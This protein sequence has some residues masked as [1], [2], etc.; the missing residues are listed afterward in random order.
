M[1]FSD[2]TN[3]NLQVIDFQHEK[4]ITHH[5]HDDVCRRWYLADVGGRRACWLCSVLPWHSQSRWMP[6]LR[7]YQGSVR[8]LLRLVL[9][10]Q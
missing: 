7:L 8:W 5:R 6:R 9:P 4:I 2:V 1:R 10:Q 3:S